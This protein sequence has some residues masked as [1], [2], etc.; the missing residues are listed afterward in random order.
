MEATRMTTAER[1][2]PAAFRQALLPKI[3]ETPNEAG[4][5]LVTTGELPGR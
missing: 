5:E 1:E 4:H 3:Q 2:R